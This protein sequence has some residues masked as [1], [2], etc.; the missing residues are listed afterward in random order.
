MNL[1]AI[2]SYVSYQA[3]KFQF[4]T[5][6]QNLLKMYLGKVVFLWKLGGRGGRGRLSLLARGFLNF[7]LKTRWLAFN[8]GRTT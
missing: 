7:P 4:V 1:T 8:L 2:D 5:E 6:K 3:N